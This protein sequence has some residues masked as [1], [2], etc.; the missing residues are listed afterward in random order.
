[1]K[2]RPQA[3]DPKAI[4]EVFEVLQLEEPNIRTTFRRLADLND[5]YDYENERREEHDTRNNT[6]DLNA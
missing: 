6:T 1:M 5:A 4:T 2:P 3:Q